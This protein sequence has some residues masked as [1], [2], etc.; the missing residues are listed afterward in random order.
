VATKP[1]FGRLPRQAPSLTATIVALA[2]E[3]QRVRESNIVDAW[4]NGGEFEGKK[5]H[6]A[7]VMKWFKARRDELSPDDPKWDYYNNQVQQYDFAIENSKAE[8][9]YKRGNKSDSQMAAFYHSWAGKL[10]KDSEAYR[11]REKLAAGYMD[12]ANAGA[13]SGRRAASDA[14]YARDITASY[15]REV[16]YDATLSF[17]TSE[18]RNRGILLDSEGLANV[19]PNTADGKAINQLWDE[20]AHSPEYEKDRQYYSDFIKKNGDPHF[21]GDFSQDA[22][23]GMTRTKTAAVG[24]RILTATKAGRQGDVTAFNK[25]KDQ[26]RGTKVTTAGFDE[27]EAYEDAHKEWMAVFQN[28][29]ST[30]LAIDRANTKYT[31]ELGKI[32]DGLKSSL[33][34]GESDQRLGAVENELKTMS[35]DENPYQHWGGMFGPGDTEGGASATE[36]AQHINKLKD[37]LALLGKKDA[38]GQPLYVMTKTPPS[39]QAVPVGTTDANHAASPWGVVKREDMDPNSVFVIQSDYNDPRA[40]G[41]T[42]A[43]SPV[44]IFVASDI[45]D[46]TDGSSTTKKS[47]VPAA[48]HY[49]LPD[50]KT[51]YK[52]RDAGGNWLYT[53]DNPFG[54][55]NPDGSQTPSQPTLTPQGG[56]VVVPGNGTAVA[57]GGQAILSGYY[58]PGS[59]KA[60]TERVGK[61][62]YSMWLIASDPKDNA[63]YTMK[64]EDIIKSLTLES[65][66]DPKRLAEMVADADSQRAIY[67]GHSTPEQDRIKKNLAN[68]ITGPV[69]LASMLPKTPGAPKS[70][71]QALIDSLDPRNVKLSS[72]EVVRNDP[73]SWARRNTLAPTPPSPLPAAKPNPT[74]LGLDI[75]GALSKALGDIF[76]GVT[77]TTAARMAT[78]PGPLGSGPMFGP[79]TTP[80]APGLTPPPA[81]PTP[82]APKPTAPTPPPADKPP[83]PFRQ[84]P[85]PPKPIKTPTAPG[86]YNNIGVYRPGG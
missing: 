61:S 47:D 62:G 32:R 18:A 30:L 59:N 60:M 7:D 63:A 81:A 33:K 4:K 35:G 14:K 75:P 79:P 55:T 29:N 17:L 85:P 11:E 12:R 41:I 38:N 2:A 70:K 20:I 24:N 36:T 78:G 72:G 6:D 25:D 68:G 45:Y 76:A 56:T 23:N 46:P 86:S 26:V 15:K 84:P 21:D 10:P 50:G 73:D 58:N 27:T 44:P 22:F 39:G 48:F 28:P 66:G 54:Q 37:D 71:E 69:S 57:S 80:K 8:L 43:V 19:D 3:Y 67:L 83:P 42:T 51:G 53:P 82:T 65:G 5:V 1:R 40:G 49:T 52:F 74:S 13:A 64:P 34:P 16:P 9:E 31:A 77:G